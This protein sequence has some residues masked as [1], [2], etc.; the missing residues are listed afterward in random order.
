MLIG[1]GFQKR[2]GKS[3][4]AKRLKRL[5]YKELTFAAPIKDA[6]KAVFKIQ[7]MYTSTRKEV[8]IPAVGKSFRTLCEEFG[9]CFRSFYGEDFLVALLEKKLEKLLKEGKDVVVSDVRHPAEIALVKKYEGHLIRVHNPNCVPDP[10]FISETRLLDY[11][12]PH[13]IINDGS[14]ELLDK[15]IMKTLADLS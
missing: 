1:L 15:R 5:G 12:W 13:T 8:I 3:T 14:L 11:V 9:Y 10:R 7:A 2:H 4:V 6:V